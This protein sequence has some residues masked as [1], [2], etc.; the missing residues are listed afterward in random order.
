M[1]KKRLSQRKR[2]RR[3]KENHQ[4]SRSQ[5]AKNLNLP[6]KKLKKRKI[7]KR[8]KS[9]KKRKKLRPR[10][11]RYLTP[12]IEINKLLIMPERKLSR[13]SYPKNQEKKILL[14]ISPHLTPKLLLILKPLLVKELKLTII[15]EEVLLQL[16]EIP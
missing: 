7:R 16:L 6:K 15:K 5:R 2:K 9:Q 3:R 4:L 10:T 13:P 1:L 12:L 8:L 14:M 11:L